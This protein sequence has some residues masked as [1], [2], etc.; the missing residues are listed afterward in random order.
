MI[1]GFDVIWVLKILPILSY[2]HFFGQ[3]DS[4]LI[5]NDYFTYLVLGAFFL[6]TKLI[7]HMEVVYNNRKL[8]CYVSIGKKLY[9]LWVITSFGVKKTTNTDVAIFYYYKYIWP[10]TKLV[11][12]SRKWYTL[13]LSIFYFVLVLF[14]QFVAKLG[15][16]KNTVGLM[17]L[18][19]MLNIR[20]QFIPIPQP[21]WKHI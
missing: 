13:I 1:F 14:Y 10:T 15:Q 11:P 7:L 21:Y 6:T 2:G 8:F 3:N 18:L 5:R 12:I 19:F 17:N 4:K 9:H 16:N 20:P